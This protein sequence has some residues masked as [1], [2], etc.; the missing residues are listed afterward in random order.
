METLP[1]NRLPMTMTPP[2]ATSGS[3]AL[4]LAAVGWA[5][6]ATAWAVAR[7]W[8]PIDASAMHGSATGDGAPGIASVLWR[9]GAALGA[10][11]NLAGIVYSL[12][13]LT[14]SLAAAAAAF[15]GVAFFVAALWIGLS[16]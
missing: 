12:P 7:H 15:C 9:G 2:P 11:A 10:A 6:G 3:R 16:G 4:W 8:V 5:L 14:R 13:A 1:P